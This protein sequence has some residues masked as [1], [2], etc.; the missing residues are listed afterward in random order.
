MQLIWSLLV[1]TWDIIIF[2]FVW[3]YVHDCKNMQ[4]KIDKKLKVML[5]LSEP[6]KYLDVCYYTAGET[7][8]WVYIRSCLFVN[9]T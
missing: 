4:Y 7:A 9:D 8:V 3:N 2:Q 5:K 1:E 6:F